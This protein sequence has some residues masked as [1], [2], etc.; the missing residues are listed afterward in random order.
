MTIQ[1]T[2]DQLH[3]SIMN[4][5]TEFTGTQINIDSETARDILAEAATKQAVRD[6]EQ[7]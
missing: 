7:Q 6:V 3:Q 2:T 5:L 1:I 4:A